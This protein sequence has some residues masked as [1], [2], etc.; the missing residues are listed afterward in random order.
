[1]KVLIAA[2]IFGISCGIYGC[3]NEANLPGRPTGATE[4]P[5]SSPGFA[6]QTAADANAEERRRAP[7]RGHQVETPA[8]VV[9]PPAVVPSRWVD[10]TTTNGTTPSTCD[11]TP[12]NCTMRDPIKGLKWSNRRPN[13]I[14]QVA[15]DHCRTLNYNG[16]T[17]WRL[18]TKDELVEAYIND[19]YSAPSM[20]SRGI[21][22][23]KR[24][25]S[26][27]S[28]SDGTDLGCAVSL[29]Y[30]ESVDA[31]Q[32]YAA[33]VVCVHGAV[34]NPPAV[35]PAGWVDVTT[36]G[37]NLTLKDTRTGLKWSNRRLDATWYDAIDHC[38][39]LNY[40]GVTGWR[41]PTKDEL[42]AA[43]TNGI[44]SA[45]R[46]NWMTK[47]DMVNDLWS[48]SSDSTNTHGAWVV[49]LRDGTTRSGYW[50]NKS[51][52]GHVVCVQ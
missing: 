40:N 25:W 42:V 2:A 8:V 45:A 52:D 13:A 41:L 15:I 50:G 7:R 47:G 26:T 38:R 3:S 49:N 10:V 1:M 5:A 32:R 48:A 24:F 28:C 6:S 20:Y 29:E 18:P 51:M 21:R 4:A 43:N 17:G 12:A 30:G 35:A 11:A 9:N 22:E 36:V 19:I 27:S 16:V 14:W 37:P 39:T 44:N 23:V 31:N 46:T 34:V 33:G